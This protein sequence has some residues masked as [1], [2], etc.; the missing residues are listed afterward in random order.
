MNTYETAQS[1]LAEGIAVFPCL[2]RSKSPAVDRWNP[3]RERLPR[4]AEL[5]AWFAHDGY[6]LAVV[7]GWQ[8]LVVVDFD[9]AWAY[10]RWLA[11]L[12]TRQFRA[13][14]QTYQVATARGVHLYYL[15]DVPTEPAKLPGVDVKA[16]GGYVLA[17]PS[18]H[19]SG[20]VYAATGTPEHL[21]HLARIE[22]VLPEYARAPLRAASHAAP[23]IW[24][25]AWTPPPLV[26]NGALER[27]KARWSTADLL[28]GAPRN[29]GHRTWKAL[30]PIHNE[31]TPS[32]VVYPDGHFK[33]YGCEA[34]G[35]VVDLYAAMHHI[36]N[37]EALAIMDV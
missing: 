26:A 3:Y 34:H 2:S 1:W 7:C 13:A 16:A 35:D 25:E 10:S 6:N 4:D 12:E 32:L 33:C 27:V 21:A 31:T 37:K 24:A 5:R 22:D 23:D 14:M 30:C 15:V 18:I 8:G 20:H 9:S 29:N 28:P 11:G 19:P 36:S 17:P